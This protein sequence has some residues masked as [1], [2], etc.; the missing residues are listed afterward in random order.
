MFIF[1]LEVVMYRYL[2]SYCYLEKKKIHID[3][4]FGSV[5]VGFS[6]KITAENFDHINKE[7]QDQL[8]LKKMVILN[9]NLL[10]VVEDE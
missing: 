6:E 9:V 5:V 7:L 3:H 1:N 8:H 10:E 4:G 2:I